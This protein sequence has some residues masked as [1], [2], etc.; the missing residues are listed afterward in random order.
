M[1]FFLPWSLALCCSRNR[2]GACAG[3]AAVARCC[4]WSIGCLAGLQAGKV[5][6]SSG[7]RSNDLDMDRLVLSKV[8]P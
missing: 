4:G 7:L 5:E 3:T 2:S 8:D 1:T 6:G